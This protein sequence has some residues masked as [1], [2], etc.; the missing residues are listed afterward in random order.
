MTP[1]SSNDAVM[2]HFLDG[3]VAPSAAPPPAELAAHLDN[4][5]S[6]QDM[7]ARGRRLDAVLASGSRPQLDRATTDRL[8]ATLEAAIAPPGEP[9]PV[10]TSTLRRWAPRAA[11]V[12]C[13]FAAALLWQGA[14]TGSA[15]I[16]ASGAS[17]PIAGGALVMAA[18]PGVEVPPSRNGVILPDLPPRPLSGERA[19]RR[20]PVPTRPRGATVRELQHLAMRR[21]LA[22]DLL[23]MTVLRAITL[24]AP[25]PED[26]SALAAEQANRLRIEA[27]TTLAESA[28][29]RALLALAEVIASEPAGA[30]LDEMVLRARTAA[31]GERLLSALDA[32]ARSGCLLELAAVIGGPRLD[33]ALGRVVDGEIEAVDRVAQLSQRVA[34][35]PGRVRLLLRLWSDLQTRGLERH[36]PGGADE[37]RP[38][39][40]AAEARA[41]QW[42][43]DLP[44][45][46]TE[47]LV[48]E[49]R[50]TRRSDQRERCLIAL[51]ARG[52]AAAIDYLLELVQGPRYDVGELAA[53]ALGQ[54]RADEVGPRLRDALRVARHPEL[55]LAALASA[56]FEG[57]SAWLDNLDLSAEEKRF[58]QAGDFHREQFRIA[59]CLIRNRHAGIAF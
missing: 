17:G 33:A 54:C 20:T 24:G 22:R 6:C 42:F 45:P 47:E 7:L 36:G 39:E 52:D 25:P 26:P 8:M 49:A 27:A 37:S 1:C 16:S 19:A 23:P 35:R 9:A 53:H 48:S 13:G 2:A 41:R 10:S 31:V 43:G 28:D 12:A 4:C 58:L 40:S 21:D 18:A 15:P 59:A 34:D 14:G 29:P 50:R 55:L 32:R 30:P 57:L 46:A 11:L 3:D 38:A 44:P 56:R 5:P 51:A